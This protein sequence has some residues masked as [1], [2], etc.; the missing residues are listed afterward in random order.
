MLSVSWEQLKIDYALP[1]S[2]VEL[3]VGESIFLPETESR[4]ERIWSMNAKSLAV[5]MKA[6]LKPIVCGL[7][8]SLL[9][10]ARVVRNA[11]KTMSLKT[12]LRW[13]SQ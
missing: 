9:Y 4:F 7:C 5:G 13:R 8:C 6:D 10:Q 12:S 11:L 2:F 1:V 3:E